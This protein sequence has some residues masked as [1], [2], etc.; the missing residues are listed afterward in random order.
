MAEIFEDLSMPY[1]MVPK[2]ADACREAGIQLMSSFFS[3]ADFAAVDPYVSLHKIASYEIGHPHLLTL[4]ARSGKPLLLSTGAAIEEEIDWAVHTFYEQG[5]Q[6]LTLLQCTACY[7]A[8][9]ATL[10]LKAIPWLRHRFHIPVGL[11]DHSPHP[12]HAAVAAVA[13][14]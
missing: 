3:P 13:L 12:L 11:S 2:L 14:G 7:P 1:E 5:G 6:D 10:H 4:A 8:D 9:P